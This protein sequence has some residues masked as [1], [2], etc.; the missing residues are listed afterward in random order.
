M[1][2]IEAKF[3]KEIQQSAKRMGISVTYLCRL[4]VGNGHLP[5]RLKAGKSVH[6]AT[7][8]KLRAYIAEYGGRK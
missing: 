2:Q 8:E 6:L 4:A 5:K 1:G 3:L 7:V